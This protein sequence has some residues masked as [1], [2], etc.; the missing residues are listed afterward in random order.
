MQETSGASAADKL[1]SIVKGGNKKKNNG[2]AK[3][4][5][6]WVAGVAWKSFCVPSF[7]CKLTEWKG[8]IWETTKIK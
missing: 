3:S 5:W 1:R 7:P 4:A 8:L 2:S 6:P